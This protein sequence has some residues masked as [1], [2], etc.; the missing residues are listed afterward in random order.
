MNSFLL[1]ALM[2]VMYTLQ[3]FFC[4]VYSDHYPGQCTMASP[5]F[6]MVSGCVVALVGLAVSGFS[7]TPSWQTVL[8]GVLNAV[9]LIAYNTC[10]IRASGSGPYSV[11]MVFMLSGGILVPAVVSLLFGDRLSVVQWLSVALIVGAIW[12]VSRKEQDQRVSGAGFFLLCGGLFL[13]NGL[14]GSLF[15]LQQR[16]TGSE[17][18]EEMVIITYL[19]T[20]VGAAAAAF[21]RRGKRLP[22]DFR[23]TRKSLVF[24]LLCSVVMAAAIHLLVYI[25]PLVNVTILYTF[26][27]A[28]VLL[29]SVLCSCVFFRE[30]LSAW[31]IAGCVLMCAGL[32]C[33]SLF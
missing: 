24:L 11:L 17:E 3:S 28:G 30:K 8:L 27:N 1:I 15:D 5:V 29:F 2:I 14:Y 33:M 26:D 31:N 4:K 16:L 10:L 12:L 19:L 22:G 9:V 13:T 7:F 32:I 25:L 21:L 20:A 23:Q 6:C 18:K